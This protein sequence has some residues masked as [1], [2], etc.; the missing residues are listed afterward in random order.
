MM[1]RKIKSILQEFRNHNATLVR[2]TKELEWAHIYHD[3]IRGNEALDK[4]SLKVGRWAGNYSFFY[5]VHRILKDFKPKKIVEFGLGESTKFI[6]TYNKSM[7]DFHEH[8]VVEHDEN[9]MK[10]FNAS[11]NLDNF[12]IN[13]NPIISRQK[14]GNSYN[15]YSN[16]KDIP[17]DADFYIVDGPFGSKRF[18]RYDIVEIVKNFK[19]DHEFIILMD[20]ANRPGELETGKEIMQSLHAKGIKY[21]SMEFEGLK[22]QLVIVSESYKYVLTV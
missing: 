5:L 13:I 9:W 21:S 6:S 2:H 18:S 19:P 1:F 10:V 4:L 20:D 3:S 12:S 7:G 14:D 11:F 17:S 16:L 8:F 15:S 22:T